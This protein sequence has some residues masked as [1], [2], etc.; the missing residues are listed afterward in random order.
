MVIAL[1]AEPGAVRD[2]AFAVDQEHRFTLAEAGEVVATIT[3]G[4]GQCDWGA[5]GRGAIA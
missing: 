5:N 4:C 2:A 1:P 3:A